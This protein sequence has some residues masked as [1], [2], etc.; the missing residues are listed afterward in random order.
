MNAMLCG[1]S[2]GLCIERIFWPGWMWVVKA[3]LSC[4]KDV[5]IS[6]GTRDRENR[7]TWFGHE[8]VGRVMD[9]RGEKDLTAVD[10]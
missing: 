9:E 4:V 8:A 10:Q 5:G 7:W 1:D 3:R 6:H 2:F